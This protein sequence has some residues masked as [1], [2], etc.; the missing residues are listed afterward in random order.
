M[1]ATS[2]WNGIH[3]LSVEPA[4]RSYVT[5]GLTLSYCEWGAADAPAVVM[6]HGGLENARAW[7]QTARALADKWRV[8]A[9][10]QRGHGE[11]GWASGGAY[12]V[13]DF[14]SDLA[15]LFEQAGLERAAVVGH[16]LGGATATC[17]AALYPEKVSRLCNV[18]GLRPVSQTGPATMD[19]HFVAIRKWADKAAGGMGGR[20]RVYPDLDAMARRLMEADPLMPEATARAFVETNAKQAQ[21]GLAW[22][23]DPLVRETALV[24]MIGPPPT[25]FWQRIECPVLLVYGKDSWAVSPAKDGRASH[26]RDARV[27]EVE[28]AGHNVHHH[29]PERF[30]D[31][32]REFLGA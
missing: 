27:V 9:V 3:R 13:L 5:R 30:V 10:D 24:T 29:Q 25:E 14:A 26:F 6:V 11:S 31:L 1:R 2:R 15:A 4:R 22:K 8:I 23:Y 7:D 21:G 18:E 28:G 20:E 19:E 12:A 16:S 17:F 32:L